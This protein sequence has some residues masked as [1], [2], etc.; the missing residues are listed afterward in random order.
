MTPQQI[1][2]S[3]LQQAKHNHN[4]LAETQPDEYYLGQVDILYKLFYLLDHV[5]TIEQFY[6]ELK[7][8]PEPR[9]SKMEIDAIYKRL[10]ER[11]DEPSAQ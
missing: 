7:S 1:I 9:V 11:R 3:E 5:P 2:A 6:T 10:T 8:V 4:K